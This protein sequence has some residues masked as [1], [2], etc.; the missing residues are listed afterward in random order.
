MANA[1]A[2]FCAVLLLGALTVV[3][4]RGA[5]PGQ[6]L[7]G[8]KRASESVEMGLTSGPEARGQKNLDFAAIR[9]DEISGLIS[10]DT[11]TAAGTG[12]A[13]A[14]L[15]PA[16]AAL[17]AE[18]LASFDRET[19]TGSQLLLPLMARTGGPLSGRVAEWAR[20]Q[21]A[22]LASI[23]PSLPSKQQ[24]SVSDS[25]RMMDQ[26]GA[27]AD[28]VDRR[29]GC[30]QASGSGGEDAFGPL[31]AVCGGTDRTVAAPSPSTT[32][33]TTGR[34]TTTRS[35]TEGTTSSEDSSRS[36]TGSTSTTSDPSSSRGLL[37]PLPVPTPSAKAPVNVPLPVPGL[38]PVSVPPLVPGMPGLSLG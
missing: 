14:G 34:K 10:K 22:H 33:S 17:V 19:R 3:I 35:T 2:G 18:N 31:P 5:L 16:T 1:L 26:L 24:T 25:R 4:S 21:S 36:T 27:R 9:L 37:P 13:A 12:P 23:G 28:A 11:A 30:P 15:D 8:V 6:M 29:R 7:Y 32:T 38:P 20:S